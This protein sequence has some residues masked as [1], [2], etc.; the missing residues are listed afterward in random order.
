VEIDPNSAW[1]GTAVKIANALGVDPYIAFDRVIV[2]FLLSG[3]T[4]PLVELLASGREPG[5]PTSLFIGG[6]LDDRM[7]AAIPADMA[8]KFALRIV[9]NRGR[10]KPSEKA[11]AHAKQRREHIE[12]GLRLLWNGRPGERLFRRTLWKALDPEPDF[13]LRAK[14]ERIDGGSGRPPDP[15]LL[16]RDFVLSELMAEKIGQG[17]KRQFADAEVLADIVRDAAAESW[18]GKLDAQTIRKAFERFRKAK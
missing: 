9:D 7:R 16:I 15:E 12:A 5:L 11:I 6:M 4:R 1:A 14:I 17:A 3:D 13:P 10:G 18:T 2:H 8:P